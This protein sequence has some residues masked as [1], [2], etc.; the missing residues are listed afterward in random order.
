MYEGEGIQNDDGY[1]LLDKNSDRLYHLVSDHYLTS[2]LPMIGEILP[3]LK[4]VLK[5]KDGNPVDIDQTIVYHNGREFKVWEAVARHAA[6]FKTG[7]SGLPEMPSGYSQTQGRINAEKG[8]PLY[9]W[10]YT[11]LVLILAGL[12]AGITWLVRKIRRRKKS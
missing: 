8:I 6:S 7:E 3:K 11:A 12:I 2:F 9:V 5:D 10:S 1:V 4:I